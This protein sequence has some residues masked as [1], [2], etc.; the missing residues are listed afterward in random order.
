VHYWQRERLKIF[1][2]KLEITRKTMKIALVIDE[3]SLLRLEVIAEL[4]TLTQLVSL[5][6]M[7]KENKIFCDF[8][9]SKFRKAL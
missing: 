2:A 6:K 8:E 9:D 7:A 5:K 3:T 4:H 1:D